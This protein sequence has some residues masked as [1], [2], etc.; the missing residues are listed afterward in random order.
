MG[1]YRPAAQGASLLIL[2]LL[3]LPPVQPSH[4]QLVGQ[5]SPNV[6][7]YLLLGEIDLRPVTHDLE[8][9]MGVRKFITEISRKLPATHRK[10]QKL[11]WQQL[12]LVDQELRAQMTRARW[13]EQLVTAKPEP[14][15]PPVPPRQK[16][17]VGAALAGLALVGASLGNLAYTHYLHNRLEAVE[18]RQ[19]KMLHYLDLTAQMTV[20]N[21]ARIQAL[22]STLQLLFLHELEFE[23]YTEKELQETRFT[24]RLLIL[25]GTCEGALAHVVKSLDR[26]MLV[27]NMAV[28][29][30]VTPELI[31]PDQARAELV[32]VKES[33]HPG[34]VMA[35]DGDS[36][37]T[38]YR[39]PCHLIARENRYVVAVPIPVY[40]GRNLFDVYRHLRT[41]IAVGEHL[42]MLVDTEGLYLVVNQERT[43]HQEMTMADL[44][45]CLLV[46]TIYLCPNQR[47]FWKS[48]QPGCLFAL[49]R[50]EIDLARR[51]CTHT[52]RLTG[53]L[54]ITQMTA[55]QFLITTTGNHEL[56]RGC[57]DRKQSMDIQIPP[58]SR[59]LTLPE[60]CSLS[61]QEAYVVPAHNQ[62][63]G[64]D[65]IPVQAE[66]EVPLDLEEV[67]KD[68]YPH[69]NFKVEEI[70]TIAGHLAR[71]SATVRVTDIL[72]ARAQV[73]P[74]SAHL[75]S[76]TSIIIT[77]V[78]LLAIVGFLTWIYYRWRAHQ[79]P[80]PTKAKKPTKEDEEIEMN[81][82]FA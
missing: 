33:L 45:T 66:K 48:T 6:A 29:G 27:W 15:T 82:E 24:Q 2:N 68:F 38:F 8:R 14:M 43:L 76:L 42:E 46:Q 63:L 9:L 55:N 34:Q 56:I 4:F 11:L 32:K 39:L 18:N 35:V 59:T 31:T 44:Q 69:L 22:N 10:E 81:E 73:P 26:L 52:F 13:L 17:F 41:P 80:R 79:T 60:G 61:S 67:I 72:A 20:E 12:L 65:V 23:R 1:V 28:H 5:M 62:T 40:D 7:D 75:L 74:R 78:G 47:R 71:Q 19:D 25:M 70:R 21:Q 53:D 57:E 37:A 58:G 49:L 77:G 51:R 3:T 64:T 50:G 36:L 30:H 16:R 54:G